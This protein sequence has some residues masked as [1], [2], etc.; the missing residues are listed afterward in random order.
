ME[1]ELRIEYPGGCIVLNLDT[2][3]PAGKER[4]KKLLRI[5]DQYAVE[6][7]ELRNTVL[8]HVRGESMK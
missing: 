6:P 5:I 7:V 3:F 8:N 2:F 4:L 1:H